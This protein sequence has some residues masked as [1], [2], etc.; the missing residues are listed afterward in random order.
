MNCKYEPNIA[1]HHGTSAIITN[2]KKEGVKN[3][4]INITG[5]VISDQK[6]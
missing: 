4:W 6:S 1:L 3:S 2:L 5:S